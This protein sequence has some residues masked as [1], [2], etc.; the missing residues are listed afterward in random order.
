ML[1]LGMAVGGL[2]FVQRRGP[3]AGKTRGESGDVEVEKGTLAKSRDVQDRT[4]AVK[5]CVP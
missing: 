1:A 2:L 4:E 5:F 3:K